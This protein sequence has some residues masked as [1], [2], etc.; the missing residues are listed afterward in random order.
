M[1]V[2]INPVELTHSAHKCPAEKYKATWHGKPVGSG[3]HLWGKVW[4]TVFTF[5][6]SMGEGWEL[7]GSLFAHCNV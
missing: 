1:L 3:M 2:Y 7:Q 6:N 5:L 4:I